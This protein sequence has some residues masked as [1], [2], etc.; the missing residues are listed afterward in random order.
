MKILNFISDSLNFSKKKIET[1][2]RINEIIIFDRFEI[3]ESN[4]CN[5]EIKHTVKN[6]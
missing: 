4:K 3:K 6:K 2:K 5:A 1:K